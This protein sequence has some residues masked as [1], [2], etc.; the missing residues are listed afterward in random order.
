MGNATFAFPLL[1]YI[2]G[3]RGSALV[4][5]RAPVPDHY[6]EADTAF[7]NGDID[8]TGL[9]L[10]GRCKRGAATCRRLH[11]AT[12]TGKVSIASKSPIPYGSGTRG[13]CPK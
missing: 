6:E 1:G 5:L 3:I 10:P 9:H 12:G 8:Q 2:R 13:N 7:L 4:N 11:E